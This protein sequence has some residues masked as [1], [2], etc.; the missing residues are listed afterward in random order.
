MNHILGFSICHKH[1]VFSPIPDISKP[2]S[3]QYKATF[4]HELGY[5][6]TCGRS[7]EK[8]RLTR[9]DAGISPGVMDAK[10][11]PVQAEQCD[12]KSDTFQ[13]LLQ[14]RKPFRA[15][16]TAILTWMRGF[17]R[18]SIIG[19]PNLVLRASSLSKTRWKLDLRH[20]RGFQKFRQK[21]K[22]DSESRPT[23]SKRFTCSSQASRVTGGC[24]RSMRARRSRSAWQISSML[25]VPADM[26]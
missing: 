14:G 25:A 11:L 26:I 9:D 15:K 7:A 12:G 1:I 18:T 2:R 4:Q 20:A 22:L 17:D 23:F 13:I 3:M 6:L 8:H 24:S 19:E 5:L 16:E 21:G 10:H